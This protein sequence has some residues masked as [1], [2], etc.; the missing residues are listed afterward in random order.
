MVCLWLWLWPRFLWATSVR[1]HL[2]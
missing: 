2:V 1:W